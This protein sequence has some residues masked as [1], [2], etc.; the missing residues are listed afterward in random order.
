[1]VLPAAVT[2]KSNANNENET[3]YFIWIYLKKMTEKKNL[4][5]VK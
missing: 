1:M 4:I 2:N 5:F 3:N